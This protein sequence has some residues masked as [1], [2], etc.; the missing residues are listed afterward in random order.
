MKDKFLKRLITILLALVMCTCLY[1]P[2]GSVVYAKEGDDST[3]AQ[4]RK[5]LEEAFGDA[6]WAL[7]KA[8]IKKYANTGRL[9][10]VLDAGHDSTHHG[11]SRSGL[12]EE[13][14][15]LKIAQY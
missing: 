3:T 8:A 12:K 7:Q 9:T 5:E 10:V 13:E 1:V 15:T 6:D 14:L 11:A 2:T 4:M